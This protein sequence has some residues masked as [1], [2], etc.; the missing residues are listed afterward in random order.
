MEQSYKLVR[1]AFSKLSAK[2]WMIGIGSLCIIIGLFFTIRAYTQPKIPHKGLYVVARDVWWPTIDVYGKEKSIVAFTNELMNA[3][4]NIVHVQFRWLDL[5]RGDLMRNLNDGFADA[6]IMGTTPNPFAEDTLVFSDT[7]LATGPVILVRQ[8]SPI[9]SL[10]EFSGKSVGMIWGL[11]AAYNAEL[12]V[13]V[14][15]YHLVRV[16]YATPLQAL[17]A[18]VKD[19]VDGVFLDTNPA[20]VLQDTLYKGLV[21]IITPPVTNQGLHFIVL[22]DAAGEKFV[23]EFDAAFETLKTDGTYDN[24]ITKWNLIDPDKRFFMSQHQEEQKE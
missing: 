24:L 1:T 8:N 16:D 22:K 21:K 19:Q 17:E 11:F 23:E 5:N 18:L 14:N 6:L 2:T 3:I 7:L 9:N 20:Y 10:K 15:D 13:V 4:A 12:Q